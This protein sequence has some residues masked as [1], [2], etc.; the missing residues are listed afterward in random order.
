MAE[1]IPAFARREDKQREYGD[2]SFERV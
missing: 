1:W 2:E